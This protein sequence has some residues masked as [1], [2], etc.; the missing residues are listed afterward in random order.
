MANELSDKA[1]EEI[2][3]EVIEGR[4]LVI[5][6]DNQLKTLHAELKLVGK[7]QEDFQ[8]RQWISSAVAYAVFAGLCVAGAIAISNARTAT[9]GADRERFEKQVKDLTAQ[10]EQ[11]KTADAALASNE[12]TANEVYKM[13]SQGQGDD[14]LKGIDALAK[15][16]QN[17][18]SPFARVVL[19]DRATLL[20][21]EV[22]AGFLERGKTAFRKQDYTTTVTEL[23]RFMAMNPVEEDALEASFFLGNALIQ[24]RKPEE[25]IPQLQRFIAGDKRAKIRDFAMLLLV[26][27]FD[28]TGQRDKATEVAREAVSTYPSSEFGASFRNRLAR[29]DPT[30]SAAPAPAAAAEPAPAPAPAPA[31]APRQPLKP[32]N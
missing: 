2:R 10:I 11:L 19:A 21:K 1:L 5:K 14:R 31:A 26:Q 20:R 16:D 6:T 13:M 32:T 3:R 22:G 15:I 8:R 12:R 30:P 7:R 9:A 23:T 17:K 24:T 25:A 27:A 4:N 18:L 28:A 29:R